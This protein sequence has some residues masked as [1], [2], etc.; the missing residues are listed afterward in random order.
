MSKK[1]V[2]NLF[3]MTMLFAVIVVSTG[4]STPS[5]PSLRSVMWNPPEKSYQMNAKWEAIRQS[6]WSV[7]GQVVMAQ[8]IDQAVMANPTLRQAWLNA[9]EAETKIDQAKSL[10]YPSLS[11]SADGQQGRSDNNALSLAT[12]VTSYGPDAT[13][14]WLLLDF[15]GRRASLRAAAEQLLSSNY[16]FNQTLQ[17]L[18]R[19]VQVGYYSLYS[20]QASVA[21][22]TANVDAALKTL[23][24]AKQ[25]E[26]A[27]LGIHLDVLQAQ[28]DYDRALYNQE[29]ARAAV[30]TAKGQLA[31]IIG[32]PADTPLTIADPETKPP[33]MDDLPRE[34]IS[35]IIDNA[36]NNRPDIAALRS[37]LSAAEYTIKSKNSD[38][39]PKFIIGGQ[40]EKTWNSYS[41]DQLTNSDSYT[42]LGSLG[43]TW[44]LFDGFLNLSKKR[45]AEAQY[46]VALAQLQNAELAASADVWS[47]YYA[48]VTS[49]KKLTFAETSL[50][51]SEE[52]YNQTLD[53]YNAGLKDIVSLLNA[54]SQLSTARSSRVT[55][56][57]E[58]NIA[59][60]DLAHAT[61]S[62]T[63]T[64]P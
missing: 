42:Y 46:Q 13:L 63:A 17:D 54:Q 27:G 61:G 45:A 47:K 10:Y 14:Q 51:S 15:G 53:S 55:A 52:A 49:T 36:M 3:Q 26:A 22:A 12:D 20:A 25:R 18:L 39:Y 16:Q 59:F 35:T 57:N 19:D 64:T 34:T 29:D 6:T 28:S 58:L 50:A 56:E 40:A 37:M 33:S 43:V 38:L 21:A 23:D 30:Y 1:I 48:F 32:L 2:G 4:C 7:T 9:K 62:L 31:Q 11:V 41:E 44:D 5:A 24:S 8:L 60:I